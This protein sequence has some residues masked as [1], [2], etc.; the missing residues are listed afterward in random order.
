MRKLNLP[1]LCTD[2]EST[3]CGD[4]NK[5][6]SATCENFVYLIMKCLTYE[7]NEESMKFLCEVEC[8]RQFQVTETWKLSSFR[9][10][11][12]GWSLASV[13]PPFEPREA[14]FDSHCSKEME[15]DTGSF[16]WQRGV[17]P[18]CFPVAFWVSANISSLPSS[19]ISY[20]RQGFWNTIK[21]NMHYCVNIRFYLRLVAMLHVSTLFL[22]H[23]Q[24][25]KKQLELKALEISSSPVG[26]G[27]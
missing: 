23:L 4:I 14:A 26:G 18:F 21:Q 10:L 9:R 17:K 6:D 2:F 5:T 24:A 1:G 25:Y 19:T 22:G 12:S 15:C 13:T 27:R 7:G 20:P 16:P 11:N 3:A 8:N